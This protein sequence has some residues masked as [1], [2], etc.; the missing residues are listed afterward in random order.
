M[1]LYVCVSDGFMRQWAHPLII[2]VSKM[3]P[4]KENKSLYLH[5]CLYPT[6]K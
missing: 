4:S 6:T 3:A 1:G 2:N 5:T